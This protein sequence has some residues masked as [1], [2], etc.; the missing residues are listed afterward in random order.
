[1]AHCHIFI[2]FIKRPAG[3]YTEELLSG[4]LLDY[5]RSKDNKFSF[6]QQKWGKCVVLKALVNPSQLMAELCI[7]IA[8][9]QQGKNSC[10]LS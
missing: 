2:Y 4:K 5:Y 9:V 8:H 3:I 7:V 1:M 10:Y 6:V